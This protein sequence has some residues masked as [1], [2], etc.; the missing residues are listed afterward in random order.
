M[1]VCGVMVC[2]LWMLSVEIQQL[3]VAHLE[4][5]D[6]FCWDKFIKYVET[7]PPRLY[8]V[9]SRLLMLFSGKLTVCISALHQRSKW[10]SS[11]RVSSIWFDYGFRQKRNSVVI[12]FSHF[13]TLTERA[14]CVGLSDIRPGEHSVQHVLFMLLFEPYWCVVTWNPHDEVIWC[15]EHRVF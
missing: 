4:G 14:C 7:M 3:F 8:W 11:N 12:Y 1:R 13:C 6:V 5:L 9:H 2:V 15:A 10:Q